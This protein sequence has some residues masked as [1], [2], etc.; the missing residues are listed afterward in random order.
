MKKPKVASHAA[1]CGS[2]GFTCVDCMEVFSLHSVKAHTSCV[3]E[4]DKYQGS[5]LKKQNASKQTQLRERSTDGSKGTLGSMRA[6]QMRRAMKD[7]STSESDDD[8]DSWIRQKKSKPVQDFHMA[9]QSAQ[10]KTDGETTCAA[11][12][13]P[14][15]KRRRSES[16]DA[17]CSPAMASTQRPNSVDVSVAREQH[18]VDATDQESKAAHRGIFT[19][20]PATPRSIPCTVP[21]FVLGEA[22]EI[23]EVVA[24]VLSE[25][26]AKEIKEKTLAKELVLRYAV[27]IAKSVRIAVASAVEGGA[28]T[29]SSATGGISLA[30]H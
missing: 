26:G 27:R 2:E 9:V 18:E 5:W 17:S 13:S 21:S 29:K 25:M 11:T 28:L 24:C 14:Q 19:S 15:L 30:R 7:L 10:E 12:A 16:R 4:T 6:Q 23:A 3:S 22:R 1:S 8:D 20:T